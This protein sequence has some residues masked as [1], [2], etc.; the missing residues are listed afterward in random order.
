[1]LKFSYQNKGAISVFLTLILLPV[2][3]FGGL[4]TDAARIYA[5]KAVISD[6]GEMAMNAGLAQYAKELHDEYGFLV[7]EK[8]PEAMQADLA[9]YFEKSLNGKG[10]SGTADYKK[11]LDLVS[12]QFEAINLEGSQIYKTEVEKQQIVEYMKYRAP[13]CLAELVLEKLDL[14]KETKKMAEAM[15]AQ[16][17][18]GEAMEDCQDSMEAAKTALDKL[19]DLLN[20][21]PGQTEI[22]QELQ[23]TKQEYENKVS[24]CLLMLAAISHYNQ[25]DERDDTE[26]SAKD[27]VEAA[28]KVSLANADSKKSFENYMSCLYYQAGISNAN[29]LDAEL[30]ADYDAQK[31][32]IAT[33]PNQ[34]GKLA[35]DCIKK[36]TDKLHAYWELSNKGLNLAITAYDKLEVVKEKLEAAS[37]KWKTWSDKTAALGEKS[38]SMKASVDEYGKFFANGDPANDKNNLGL[39][40]EDVKTD[41]L[42]FNEM[43]DILPEE[44]FF[45]QSIAKVGSSEQYSVYLNKAKAV[46]A[47]D[48]ALFSKVENQRSPSY[49]SNYEH[50]TISTANSMKRIASSEFYKKLKDYCENAEEDPNKKENKKKANEYL[51][52]SEEAGESAKQEDDSLNYSWAMDSAMP[53]VAL[54]LVSSDDPDGGLVDVGGDVN[55]KAGRKDAISKFKSSINEAT[56]F[57]DGLERIIADNLENLY[58]AEYAIQMLSYYTVDK[59]NGE[60]LSEDEVIGLSGY[61]L[62]EHKAYKAE[63]EYVLW[64]NPSSATNVKNTMMVIFGIRLLF[65]AIFACTNSGVV[66]T[67]Q[68]MATAI[69]GAAPYLIPIVQVII[70]LALAGM[71]TVNDMAKIKEGYGVTI[72]KSEESWV[73]L[74]YGGD[75]TKGLTLNYPEFLRIFLNI[76]MLGGK[77]VKKLARIADCVRVNTDFDMIH[78]YTMLAVEAKVGVRTTFMKKIS[79]LGAGGW[80]QADNTYTVQYQSLLGY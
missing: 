66:G 71:E 22:E 11:I 53:S 32:A 23:N 58:V 72:I 47:S 73:S 40:M 51:E 46:A 59:K 63:V 18:F 13:V 43:R 57:L 31:A 37:E 15:N 56:S 61:K 39:L 50:T 44:K 45:G 38:G 36:H 17:D 2:L 55:D 54:H 69:A 75:N 74:P 26:A 70:E 76:N 6:A 41:Q 29:D 7:M 62:K 8:S 42:Y 64:G 30:K 60:T 20:Q 79:D 12:K 65:N 5:S 19:N 67:A 49:I 35:N 48:M 52:Q 3:L 28:K 27:F 21:F 25:R 16:M 68:S 34:L 4:T 24:R 9:G 14:M 10:I 33:Y 1:M 77:E 78:G 80:T